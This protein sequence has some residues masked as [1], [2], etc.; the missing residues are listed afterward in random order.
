MGISMKKF[1]MTSSG[2]EVLAYTLTGE[3]GAV[4]TLLNYGGTVQKLEIPDS[5]G[6]L[7]DVVLGYDDMA[8]YESSHNMFQGALIGRHGNRIENAEFELGGK[9]FKLAKNNGNN[10]L[11]GGIKGFDKKIWLAET[12]VNS[13]GPAVR[14]KLLSPD[15][16]EG[17]PGNLQVEVIYTLTDKNELR[18]EYEAVSDQDTVINLT[19]HAYFNLSGHGNGTIL[20]HDMR[21]NADSFTTINAECIPD[22]SFTKVEATPLDFRQPTRIGNGIDAS[23]PAIQAGGG[24]DHNFV[25]NG[26]IGELRDCAEV[27]DPDSGRRMVVKTTL[28]GVQFYS[29]NFLAEHEG[30][31]GK[32]YQK[33]SG[34]CLE[35]QFFPNSLKHKNFPSPVFKAGEKFKHTTVYEFT[36]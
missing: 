28:P 22:G 21:I 16:D 36:K 29:G 9:I 23:H 4:C 33:R 30:K 14:F 13:D 20:N 35:T 17:Y 5:E 26:R 11:H 32:I 1:G 27:Y 15:M 7:A 25:L 2:D 34:F 10:H 19:N 31:A 12:F 24:Y 18:I 3:G 8:G 6:N